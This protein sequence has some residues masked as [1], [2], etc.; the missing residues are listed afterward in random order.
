MS[1]DEHIITEAFNGTYDLLAMLD[2]V[3]G[4]GVGVAIGIIIGWVWRS[5]KKSL[6]SKKETVG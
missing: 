1:I 2:P 4:I 6:F 3:N 5:A